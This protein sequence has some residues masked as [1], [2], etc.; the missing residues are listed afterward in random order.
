MS[1]QSTPIG[2]DLSAAAEKRHEMVVQSYGRLQHF[3]Y[4]AQTVHNLSNEDVVVT[5]IAVDSRW[6]PLVDKLMPNENW[7]AIRDLGQ[8]PVARGTA[9]FPI[10]KVI[11]EA[12]PDL[13]EVLLEKPSEGHYKLIA[14]DDGGCTVYEIEPAEEGG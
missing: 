11:A 7:Q 10:C 14:L 1:A 12:M 8:I 9:F 6:R 5:C 4:R 13:A 3:A 2:M